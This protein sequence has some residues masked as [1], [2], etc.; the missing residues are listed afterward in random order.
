MQWVFRRYLTGIP[1]DGMPNDGIPNNEMSL[2]ERFIQLG[3]HVKITINISITVAF[4]RILS[5]VIS[6]GMSSNHIRYNM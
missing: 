6:N 4:G 1:N 2:F 3:K 5:T